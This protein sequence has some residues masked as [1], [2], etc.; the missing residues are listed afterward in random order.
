MT[1]HLRD[2][3]HSTFAPTTPSIN[4][5]DMAAEILRPGGKSFLHWYAQTEIESRVYSTVKYVNTMLWYG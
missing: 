3:P 2:N 1:Q 4:Y 5:S